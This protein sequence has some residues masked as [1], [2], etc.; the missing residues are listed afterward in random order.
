MYGPSSPRSSWRA[1]QLSG[2]FR[3]LLHALLANRFARGLLS[4]LLRRFLCGFTL[5]GSLHHLQVPSVVLPACVSL[6]TRGVNSVARLISRARGACVREAE[7]SGD[8]APF[9]LVRCCF[10]RRLRSLRQ[11]QRATFAGFIS[12]RIDTVRRCATK[13]QTPPHSTAR[14]TYRARAPEC[15][16]IVFLESISI[17]HVRA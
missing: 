9:V 16:V 6:P 15:K 12:A 7:S 1:W 4:S 8:S 13:L 3:R 10:M 17:S 5:G 2:R 11:H 14:G